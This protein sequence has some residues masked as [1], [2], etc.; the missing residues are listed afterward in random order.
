MK[1]QS[2]S[3]VFGLLAW[4]CFALAIGVGGWFRNASAPGVAATVWTLTALVLLACWKIGIIREWIAVVDLR[5]LIAVH[6]TRFVGIYF[7]VL[8]SRGELPQ[9]FAKPAGVGDIVVAVG[10]VGLLFALSRDSVRRLM[11]PDAA[12][13]RPYQA[14]LVLIWNALGLIDIVFVAF[15]ALRFG[16]K[17]WQAMAALREL[18]LSLLPT[19]IVPLIIVSH[20]LIFVRLKVGAASSRVIK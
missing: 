4:L 2:N 3:V 19:F 7:L 9:G 10:A 12:A 11:D 14:G 15:A 8:G 1:Q 6:L 5:W 17:D 13:R 20:I 16:L 18:P